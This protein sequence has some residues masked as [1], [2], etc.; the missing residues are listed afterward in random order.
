MRDFI[1]GTYRHQIDEKGRIRIP[2]K[3]KDLLGEKLWISIGD[4]E[5]LVIYNEH[6]IDKMYDKYGEM[7]S[8]D[9]A[10]RRQR[11]IFANTFRF[12]GD[13]QNRFQIPQILRDLI[14]L[15]NEALFVG[16]A[17]RLE[18]WRE[19]TYLATLAEDNPN[20]VIKGVGEGE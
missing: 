12:Q 14:G 19:D 10:Y 7:E 17:N 13:A 3:I 8:G 2:A 1:S 16:M 9:P 5:N 20:R 4:Q 6:T 11:Y 18:I 15:K